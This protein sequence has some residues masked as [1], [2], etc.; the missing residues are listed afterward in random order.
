MSGE[1]RKGIEDALLGVILKPRENCTLVGSGH[2]NILK[3][4]I[5]PMR[6][7]KQKISG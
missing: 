1:Q 2:E 3:A 5:S 6:M 7:K 4:I